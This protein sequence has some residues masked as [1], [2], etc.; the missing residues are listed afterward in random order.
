MFGFLVH[1]RDTS[2]PSAGSWESS[3]AQLLSSAGIWQ[4]A[5]SSNPLAQRGFFELTPVEKV[6]QQLWSLLQD[7][8]VY[9]SI[10]WPTT[11]LLEQSI[12]TVAAQSYSCH[13]SMVWQHSQQLVC[14]MD[15]SHGLTPACASLLLQASVLYVL[16]DWKSQ[17]DAALRDSLAQQVRAVAKLVTKHAPQLTQHECISRAWWF[18][19]AGTGSSSMFQLACNVGKRRC[20]LLQQK[21]PTV[22]FHC[23]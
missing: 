11:L 14:T 19:S 6:R 15:N 2:V 22:C 10:C 16:C 12:T 21:M 4:R 18:K 8:W 20:H 3:L 23:A 17:Q 7:A 9:P 13:Y 5:F 1:C